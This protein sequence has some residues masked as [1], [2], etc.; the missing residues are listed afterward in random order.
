MSRQS[1]PCIQ[2]TGTDWSPSVDTGDQIK[3]R[4]FFIGF[5]GKYLERAQERGAKDLT[6]KT[7]RERDP[8]PR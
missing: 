1:I 5:G 7:R 2:F 3:F 6:S 4:Q 8:E